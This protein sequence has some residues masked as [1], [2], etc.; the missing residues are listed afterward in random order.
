[1]AKKY[2]QSVVEI[3]KGKDLLENH[4]VHGRIQLKKKYVNS[5]SHL[6][7]NVE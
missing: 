1:M 2:L 3:L 7:Q 6:A 5:W 4:G